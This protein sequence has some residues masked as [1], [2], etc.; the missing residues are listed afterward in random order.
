[1]FHI[2]IFV[3]L[4]KNV[5]LYI[6]TS[7]NFNLRYSHSQLANHV[8]SKHLLT[9]FSN[10]RDHRIIFDSN[11]DF[12]VS[13]AHLILTNKKTSIQRNH[14]ILVFF[15]NTGTYSEILYILTY[16]IVVVFNLKFSY[17]ILQHKKNRKV[18][19]KTKFFWFAVL[20]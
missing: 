3:Q 5:F 8:L 11:H 19:C 14:F 4:L 7:I 9:V 6:P 2:N 16:D 13:N 1:M 17:T 18:C 20:F 15:M 10:I 12:G